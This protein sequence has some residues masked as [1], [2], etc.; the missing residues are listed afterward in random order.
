MATD[1]TDAPREVDPWRFAGSFLANMLGKSIPDEPAWSEIP[2]APVGKPLAECKVALLTTAGVS[3][4]DD[5][6]FDMEYE[7]QNPTR[8]DGSFRKLRGDATSYDVAVNHLH[9][10][11][12]YIER[13][14]NV[15]LPIARLGE[16]VDQG[17]VGSAAAT[18]YSIMGFQGNDSS[19]LEKES[20]PE[21]AR[22]LASEEVDLFLLA[23]V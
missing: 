12:S 13:D 19:R 3:M 17:V 10:D 1:Q 6:P 2:F 14:L 9:I 7:R 8:G 22:C 20:A 15:A 11:T 4:K 16:L 23:P 5:E 18:H 21:I